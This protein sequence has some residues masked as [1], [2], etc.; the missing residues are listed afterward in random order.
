MQNKD[1]IEFGDLTLKEIGLDIDED[2]HIVD[3]ESGMPILVKGKYLKY[4]YGAVTRTTKDEIN[5]DPLNNPK[6]MNFLFG[7]YSNKLEDEGLRGVDI[8]VN[9]AGPGDKQILKV[10]TGDDT[11]ESN[12]YHNESVRIMDIIC[13]INESGEDVSKFDFKSEP[14]VKKPKTTKKK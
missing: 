2:S 13:Q 11:L 4:N 8:C 12:P 10:K 3:E 7:Y 6:L 9:T 14:V 5:Y 1:I